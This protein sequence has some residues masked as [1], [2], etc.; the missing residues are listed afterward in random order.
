MHTHA[1]IHART[2]TCAYTQVCA[3]AEAEALCHVPERDRDAALA[4]TA[5]ITA[6]PRYHTV[7]RSAAHVLSAT[8]VGC[9]RWRMRTHTDVRPPASK[10]ARARARVYALTHAQGQFKF[11]T[12]KACWYA[13]KV[14]HVVAQLLYYGPWHACVRACM[15]ACRTVPFF[16]APASIRTCVDRNV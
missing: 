10:Q 16:R 15:C 11:P 7:Q 12:V 6:I 5:H 2:H 13:I 9:A 8:T 4:G 1:H 3:A 14:N